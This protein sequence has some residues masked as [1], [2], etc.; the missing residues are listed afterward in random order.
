MRKTRKNPKGGAS[1]AEVDQ[2]R[3]RRN[4]VI[5]NTV[6]LVSFDARGEG[7]GPV[8]GN[9]RKRM[10]TIGSVASPGSVDR[11][12]A[13]GI[14]RAIRDALDPNKA[15]KKVETFAEMSDEKKAEMLQLYGKK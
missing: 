8:N 7:T 13:L 4:H 11:S 3:L 10:A 14:S 2:L 12:P 15:P 1:T 5:G 6:K 9:G